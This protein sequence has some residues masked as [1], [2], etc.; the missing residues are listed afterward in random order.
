MRLLHGL[1]K[2]Q[3]LIEVGPGFN[4]AVPKRDGW[5]VVTVDH[6]SREELVAK[7]SAHQLVD[8]SK[9]EEVDFVWAHGDLSAA[10][11]QARHGTFDACI[12]SHLIEHIPDLLGFLQSVSK[13]LALDGAL[14]LAI[15]DKRYCFDW[16][17]PHS[18][19][20][21]V[22]EA[23]HQKRSRHTPGTQY[24]TAAY[25]CTENG[26]VAWGQKRLGK[27]E[28]VCPRFAAPYD[29][30]KMAISSPEQFE[31]CHAWQFTPSSFDLIMLELYGL[32]LIDL[33]VEKIF[34][35]DGSD[36]LAIMRKA[37]PCVL[38][39]EEIQALRIQKLRQIV[40][41][42]GEQADHQRRSVRRAR[43]AIPYRN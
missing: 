32:A 7:Y 17:R 6:A 16:F 12:A 4:P 25:T 35:P 1:T 38:S 14:H 26:V 20:G 42:L 23:H 36:F 19:T 28:M 13:L 24:D 18:T 41:E 29:H 15:P 10:I 31:D 27:I 39:N 9:I 5:N 34:P 3:R 21:Q 40:E 43:Y 33:Q 2:Q 30:F 37:P 8:T 22:L 11:P